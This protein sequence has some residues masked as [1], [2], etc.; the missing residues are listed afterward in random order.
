M[1]FWNALNGRGWFNNA[2][3]FGH[4][5][6]L[7]D[8]CSDI[9]DVSILPNNRYSVGTNLVRF[10]VRFS[11]WEVQRFEVQFLGTK[12]RFGRFEVRFSE[13]LVRFG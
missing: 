8:L 11:F 9:V 2:T 3:K 5:D 7:C 10:E 4:A 13:T 12:Q 6:F 1:R